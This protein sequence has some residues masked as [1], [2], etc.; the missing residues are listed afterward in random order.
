M[1]LLVFTKFV[2]FKYLEPNYT[3]YGTEIKRHH[4]IHYIPLAVGVMSL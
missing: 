4:V 3:V 1:H 2:E